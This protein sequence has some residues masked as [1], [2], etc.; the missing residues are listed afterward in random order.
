MKLS[1]LGTVEVLY[2]HYWKIKALLED[3]T[4]ISPQ[5][6]RAR[7]NPHDVLGYLEY[8]EYVPL[9]FPLLEKKFHEYEKKLTD[10]GVE[11]S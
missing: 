1:D 7:I 4:F 8:D 9:L 2:G 5:F 11:L 10:L 3:S 6:G